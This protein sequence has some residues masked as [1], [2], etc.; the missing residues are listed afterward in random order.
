VTTK[1]K[2]KKPLLEQ[3]TPREAQV[4][5]YLPLGFSYKQIANKI[6][7]AESTVKF[8]LINLLDKTGEDNRTTLAVRYALE[9]ARSEQAA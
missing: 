7:I 3:A 6:G 1:L 5:E 9:Q 2:S 4:L 8:H